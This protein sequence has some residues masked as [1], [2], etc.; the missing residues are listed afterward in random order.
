MKSVTGC[1]IPVEVSLPD[2]AALLLGGMFGCI[3]A[4]QAFRQRSGDMD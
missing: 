2:I 3:R 1:S 4:E